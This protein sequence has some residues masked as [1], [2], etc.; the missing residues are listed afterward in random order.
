MCV[1]LICVGY[2]GADAFMIRHSNPIRQ[3][4]EVTQKNDSGKAAEAQ[5]NYSSLGVPSAA[6]DN[7]LMLSS[8][9]NEAQKKGFSSISFE[10][11]REDGTIGYTSN[12]TTVDTFGAISNPAK[13]LHDSLKT[14]SEKKITPI[15]RICCL[16]DNAAAKKSA[17]MAVYNGDKVYT[18]SDGNRYLNP[19]NADAIKYL[20]D[21]VIESYN[22]GIRIFVLSSTDLPKSVRDGHNDGF[23]AISKQLAGEVGGDAVFL[24]AVNATVNGW[25]EEY[26]E[27]NEEGLKS[28][29][30][31]LDALKSNQI[32]VISTEKDLEEINSALKTRISGYIIYEE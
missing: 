18:D 21:I 28:E 32:Y 11:K 25:S 10:L 19:D 3:A 6:L 31:K 22:L 29:I 15:A 16:K 5:I 24:E 26:G 9:I 7:S 8:V 17:D 14:L 12:L 20:K 4:E 2:I 23:A 30:E 13:K 27:Y 1:I